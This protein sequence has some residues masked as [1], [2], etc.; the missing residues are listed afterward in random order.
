MA[1]PEEGVSRR[2]L[3]LRK[4][5]AEEGLQLYRAVVCA[6]EQGVNRRLAGGLQ[7][8]ALERPAWWEQLTKTAVEELEEAVGMMRY[9]TDNARQVS[10]DVWQE[11]VHL[12]LEY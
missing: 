3:K 5:R 4:Q 11:T 9:G 6:R 2:Q 8:V 1:S 12:R 10:L 7:G